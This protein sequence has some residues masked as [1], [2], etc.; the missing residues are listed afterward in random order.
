[1]SFIES[2]KE[3]A[4]KDIKQIVLPEATDLRV[5]TA[6][7]KTEQEGFAKVILIGNKEE[8]SKVADENKIDISR[9][10]IN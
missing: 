6:A 9:L 1:M 3:R 2:I 8:I 10:N 5:L 4:K 7:V